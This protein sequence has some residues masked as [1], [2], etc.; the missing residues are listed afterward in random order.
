MGGCCVHHAIEGACSSQAKGVVL[1]VV[2]YC[3][4]IRCRCVVDECRA[5]GRL[6]I[7]CVRALEGSDAAV[8][9]ARNSSKTEQSLLHLKSLAC[10]RTYGTLYQ[11]DAMHNDAFLSQ[12]L[13]VCLLIKR[14]EKIRKAHA[15]SFDVCR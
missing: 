7:A 2:V 14:E 6:G 12:R 11:Q 4:R 1:A 3:A 13:L 15:P 10:V 5:L 8:G 9:E